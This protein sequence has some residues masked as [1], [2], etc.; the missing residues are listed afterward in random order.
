MQKTILITGATDGIGLK[1]AQML[2]AQGHHVL[3][4]GRNAEKLAKTKQAL[5]A[6]PSTLK[7][8]GEVAD[9]IDTYIADLSQMSQVIAL[10]EAVKAAHGK[11]DV[12]I[13]N[14]GVF[15]A[16]NNTTLE[17]L[18]I[19]FA[20]NTIAPYLLTHSLLPLLG[21]KGRVIN[22]SSA[23]QA[24]V[25]IN[26]LIGNVV[27]E[28]DFSAYA[29][30]KLALTMWSKALAQKADSPIVIAVNPGSMLGSKM[31]KDNFGVEGGDVAKGAHI[32]MRLALDDEFESKSG[33]YFDN[34]LGH[35]STPHLDALEVN[36]CEEIVNGIKKILRL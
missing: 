30:S 32:L 15:R 23:A 33:G 16:E 7:G 35:F 11:I 34:D 8:E 26:A 19:R 18:D 9:S 17:G 24:T 31:V 10:A 21:E 4:H 5:I 14:A 28:D 2:V 13:N 12:L 25:N 22:L 3:L 36:K 1:T 6:N 29:Q 27:V 20:V